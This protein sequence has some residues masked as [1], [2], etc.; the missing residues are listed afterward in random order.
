MFATAASEKWESQKIVKERKQKNNVNISLQQLNEFNTLGQ[1]IITLLCQLKQTMTSEEG[2]D[3]FPH[4]FK[5]FPFEDF[6][7]EPYNTRSSH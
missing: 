3:N 1:L 7:S 4:Q 2:F 5:L 6:L